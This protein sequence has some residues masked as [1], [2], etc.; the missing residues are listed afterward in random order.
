M[1]MESLAVRAWEHAYAHF[2]PASVDLISI[3]SGTPA[4]GTTFLHTPPTM[5][6]EC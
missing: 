1:G 5:P 2:L 3:Y 4:M 6:S